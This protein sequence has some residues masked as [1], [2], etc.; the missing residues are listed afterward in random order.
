MIPARAFGEVPRIPFALGVTLA[1]AS[2][3]AALLGAPRTLAI[4]LILAAAAAL[5]WVSWRRWDVGVAI[6]FVWITFEDLVRKFSGNSLL[7]YAGKD[8]IFLGLVLGFVVALRANREP[9]LRTRL[10]I[11]AVL[12]FLLALV[13]SIAPALEN[14]RVPLAGLHTSFLFAPFLFVG[15]ALAADRDR[16][17]HFAQLALWTAAII[18]ALAIVQYVVGPDF[19]NPGSPVPGTRLRL[20]RQYVVDGK[21]LISDRPNGT[22]I[23]AGRLAQYLFASAALGLAFLSAR[24]ARTGMKKAR[25][26]FALWALVV[27]ALVITGQRA[28]LVL[29]VAMPVLVAM[30]WVWYRPKLTIRWKPVLAAGGF[31]LA[32]AIAGLALLAPDTL[33]FYVWTFFGPGVVKQFALRSYGYTEAI[34]A[35]RDSLLGHGTGTASLGKQYATGVELYNSSSPGIYSVEGGYAMVAWEWGAIGLALWLALTIGLV[36]TLVRR[37]GRLRNSPDFMLVATL[38]AYIAC[39]LF[40]YFYLGG[41]VYQNYVTQSFLW[42]FTGVAFQLTNRKADDTP[43]G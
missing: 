20:T 5:A 28:S 33:K 24:V 9:L 19:L 41:Q 12:L 34:A 4:S 1:T 2:I 32:A 25:L 40:P 10:L 23:D 31:V 39:V 35:L 16:W 14:P 11:P 43:E 8:L 26:P 22:F 3:L 37:L 21:I 30:L 42:L 6:F 29:F 18:A 27:G 17:G 13:A 7:I 38:I 36:V 15:Y